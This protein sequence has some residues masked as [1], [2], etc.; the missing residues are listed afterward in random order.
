MKA[1]SSILDK[2]V[3][4]AAALTY[5]GRWEVSV[6]YHWTIGQQEQRFNKRN[7][8]FSKIPPHHNFHLLYVGG[9]SF[10]AASKGLLSSTQAHLPNKLG[11]KGQRASKHTGHLKRI[12]KQWLQL[13][14]VFPNAYRNQITF[15][16][17]GYVL[18]QSKLC[19]VRHPD[20]HQLLS[21]ELSQC[22]SRFE[23]GSKTLYDQ[24]FTFLLATFK[25]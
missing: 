13:Q 17:V 20:K 15:E 19:S 12:T 14:R 9:F 22:S 16:L 24:P 10:K 23:L 8:G 3:T 6:P 1:N 25:N 11:Y 2:D 5:T 4:K 7:N 21:L 18:L